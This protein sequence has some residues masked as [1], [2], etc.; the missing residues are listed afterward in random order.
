MTIGTI[1]CYGCG[2]NVSSTVVLAI[3]DDAH[4]RKLADNISRGADVTALVPRNLDD[5]PSLIKTLRQM[6]VQYVGA[7]VVDACTYQVDCVCYIGTKRHKFTCPSSSIILSDKDTDA[8]GTDA[9][10]MT[11]NASSIEILHSDHGTNAMKELL[12]C[13]KKHLHDWS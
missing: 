12:Y 9:R 5:I 1:Q 6:D 8:E 3:P 10:T 13:F 7:V 4:A 2:E 11:V